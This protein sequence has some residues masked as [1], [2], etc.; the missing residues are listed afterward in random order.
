ME[1]YLT[2]NGGRD[3]VRVKSTTFFRIWVEKAVDA[4]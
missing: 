1:E 3:V 2:I 4:N